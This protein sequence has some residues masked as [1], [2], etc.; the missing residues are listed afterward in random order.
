MPFACRRAS[1]PQPKSV[2]SAVEELAVRSQKALPLQLK[3]GPSCPKDHHLQSKS[4]LFAVIKWA[5]HCRVGRLLHLHH[6]HA[7]RCLTSIVAM[8]WCPST[9]SMYVA[10]LG[11][12][13]DH[14]FSYFSPSNFSGKYTVLPTYAKSYLRG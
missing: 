12:V 11:C 9:L 10:P 8:D 2:Q 14:Y 13:L 5:V 6:R 7:R 3:S 1:C 4:R